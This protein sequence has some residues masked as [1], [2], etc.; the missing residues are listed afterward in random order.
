V[1]DAENRVEKI[2]LPRTDGRTCHSHKGVSLLNN[3]TPGSRT[4]AVAG[5]RMGLDQHMSPFNN[6]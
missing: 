2:S 5:I 1:S 3:E 6:S 4:T